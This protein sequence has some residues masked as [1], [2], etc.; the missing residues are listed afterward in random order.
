MKILLHLIRQPL[1][2]AHNIIISVAELTFCSNS[3]VLIQVLE[4]SMTFY[5]HLLQNENIEGL[6]V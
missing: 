4:S 2:L 6:S 5:S 1:H 3:L